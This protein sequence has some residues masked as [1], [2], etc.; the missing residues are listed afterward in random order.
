MIAEKQSEPRS[1]HEAAWRCEW[2]GRDA[3]G[4]VEIDGERHAEPDAKQPEHGP[5]E[6]QHGARG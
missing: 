2:D 6:A 5:H 1:A 3:R 4:R